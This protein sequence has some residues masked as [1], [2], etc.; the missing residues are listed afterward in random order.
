MT[1]TPL[2]FCLHTP[3]DTLT[4]SGCGGRMSGCGGKNQKINKNNQLSLHTL[5]PHPDV[6]PPLHASLYLYVRGPSFYRARTYDSG[7]PPHVRPAP[8]R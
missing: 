8:A 4:F 3:L 2:H 1:S 5:A 6:E 7:I